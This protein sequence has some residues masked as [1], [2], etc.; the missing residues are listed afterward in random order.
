MLSL[1]ILAL[2]AG[3]PVAFYL[4]CR[5]GVELRDGDP[6]A[7]LAILIAVLLGGAYGINVYDGWPFV[8]VAFTVFMSFGLGLVGSGSVRSKRKVERT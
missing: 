5:L 3:V 2:V 8:Q 4:G 6:S 7:L 1:I